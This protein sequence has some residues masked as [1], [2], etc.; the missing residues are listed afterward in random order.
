VRSEEE[1]E[2]RKDR[3]TDIRQNLIPEKMEHLST[4]RFLASVC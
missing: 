2:S 4:E 1:E 3:E